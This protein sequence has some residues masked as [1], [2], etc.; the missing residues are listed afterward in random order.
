MVCTCKLGNFRFWR[1]PEVLDNILSARYLVYIYIYGK[2]K[3]TSSKPPTRKVPVAT[4]DY[5]RVW[6]AKMTSSLGWDL[7]DAAA[8]LLLAMAP[9]S[10][11]DERSDKIIWWA[12]SHAVAPPT[13]GII[14]ITSVWNISQPVLTTVNASLQNRFKAEFS[15]IPIYWSRNA[16]VFPLRW[17]L[18]HMHW[19]SSRSLLNLFFAPRAII[20]DFRIFLREQGQSSAM[21]HGVS[22]DQIF[23][24]LDS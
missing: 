18:S 8:F 7:D 22:M 16:I 13:N 15:D 19:Q 14:D 11:L 21:D 17:P 2:I 5:R 23:G 6:Q 20:F 4:F 1:I 3:T 12:V 9:K 10:P 24:H